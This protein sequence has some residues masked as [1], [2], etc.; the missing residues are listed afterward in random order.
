MDPVLTILRYLLPAA[1]GAGVVMALIAMRRN[2]PA[3]AGGQ[4][5]RFGTAW[6]CAAIAVFPI[7]GFIAFA[8]FFAAEDQRLIAALVATALTLAALIVGYS[9]FGFEAWWDDT[10]YGERTWPWPPVTVA[11]GDIREAYYNP[12]TQTFV[13]IR[14]DGRKLGFAPMMDNGETFMALLAERRP[15]LVQ[16]PQQDG[17]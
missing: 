16:D 1:V 2:A 10:G 6:R 9:V 12:V 14:A 5:I 7:A 15:D 4:V 3:S 11:W 13:M 8:A 17:A